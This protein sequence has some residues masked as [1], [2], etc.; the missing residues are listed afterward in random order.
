M[1]I[2]FDS[3]FEDA[4]LVESCTCKNAKH[5]FSDGQLTF[6]DIRDILTKVFSGD[7][8]MTEKTNGL[9]LSMTFKDGKFCIAQD[10]EQLS[11]PICIDD[12]SY[13]VPDALD[14]MVK[15]TVSE[16]AEALHGLDPVLLNKY[17]ANGQNFMQFQVVLPPEANAADYNGRCFVVL[18]CIKCYNDKFDEIGEDNESS[19]ALFDEMKQNDT[20]KNSMV[21]ISEPSILRLKNAV[22]AKEA[23]DKLT[24]RLNLFIDGVGWRCSINDYVLDKYSRHI[25]NK[26]LEHGLDVSKSSEFVNEL[27]SRLS[28]IS[29]RKPTRSDLLTYAK[30]DQIDFKSDNY[31][32]FIEDLET[33]A[34]ATNSEI[35]KPIEDLVFD[36]GRML[37]A[38][39]IGYMAV[40]PSTTAKKA[41]ASVGEISQEN[42]CSAE[43]IAQFKKSLAK[44]EQY[45]ETMPADGI[46]FMYK[47]KPYKLCGGWSPANALLDLIKYK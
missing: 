18:Q 43:S 4:L 44:V 15:T 12:A 27:A 13:D 11:D 30:R 34:D 29:G 6:A 26:A 17:F 8:R 25:V 2:D 21:E 16:V 38:N 42:D 10:S 40:D 20:V 45:H 14:Q 35:I 32:A 28:N 39:V 1:A 24:S 19:T 5:I 41:L 22:Q 37:M 23:L 7:L 9:P 33:N 31:R 3:M 46:V 47:S 36:A